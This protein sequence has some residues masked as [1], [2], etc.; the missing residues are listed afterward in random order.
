MSLLRNG[1]LGGLL[2]TGGS[3]LADPGL[4]PAQK[5]TQ[6]SSN[7]STL[8]SSSTEPI[9]LELDRSRLVYF[10]FNDLRY[11]STLPAYVYVCSPDR[12]CLESEGNSRS[13]VEALEY[14]RCGAFGGKWFPRVGRGGSSS[15]G[16]VRGRPE[17]EPD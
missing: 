13:S 1:S 16:V 9:V 10:G 12:G 7:R 15:I 4:L 11:E 5:F 17:R 6:D 3:R 14:G 2:V 8:T